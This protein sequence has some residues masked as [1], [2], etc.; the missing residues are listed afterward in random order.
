MQTVEALDQDYD[1]LWG[2]MIKQTLRRVH[3]GFS[4]T[5]YGYRGF[6]DLMKGHRKPRPDHCRIRLGP[7]Q[8][9]SDA[10]A[11]GLRWPKDSFP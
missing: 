8:L 2:S 7:R 9:Q 6:P 11:I 1:T 10:Q 5:Y 3:P 4:E